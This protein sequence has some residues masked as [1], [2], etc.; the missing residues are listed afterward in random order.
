VLRKGL[1]NFFNV[2]SSLGTSLDIVRELLISCEVHCFFVG[3]LALFLHICQV[4]NKVEDDLRICVVANLS[5]PRILDAFKA[6][7]LRD[8]EDKE[9]TIASLIE[10]SRD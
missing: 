9:D 4:A 3:N 1:E 10:V 8:V 5:Q 7:A 6:T 2:F